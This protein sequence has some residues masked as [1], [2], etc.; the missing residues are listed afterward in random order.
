MRL[1]LV[2]AAL[3]ASI[4]AFVGALGIGLFLAAVDESGARGAG[5]LLLLGATVAFASSLLVLFGPQ[6]L[7]RGGGRALAIL[8][9]FLAIVPLVAISGVALSFSGNPMGSAS[10][11]L[12]WAMFAV[13]I[14]LALGALAF[15]ALAVSKA[16]TRREPGPVET[17]RQAGDSSGASISSRSIDEDE[18]EV[19]VIAG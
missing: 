1:L 3:V 19:R 8:A 17:A 18:E 16:R 5:L 6:R 9:G 14:L 13:G 4:F 12:D 11:A 7:F 15:A 2:S 10:P